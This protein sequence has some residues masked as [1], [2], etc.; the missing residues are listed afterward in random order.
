MH[1]KTFPPPILLSEL[2][3]LSPFSSHTPLA[4][5]RTDLFLVAKHQKGPFQPWVP[6][7]TR[8]FWCSRSW[9]DKRM[10]SSFF[11]EK[12][13]GVSCDLGSAAVTAR[14]QCWPHAVT[15]SAMTIRTQMTAAG[16]GFLKLGSQA[17]PPVSNENTDRAR[18]LTAL[19]FL[20]NLRSILWLER[21]EKRPCQYLT[22]HQSY[23][24]GH[25]YDRDYG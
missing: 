17:A 22:R 19:G 11:H 8:C 1:I 21:Q 25:S 23:C 5:G 9:Q 16:G 20:F 15:P 7:Q 6:T 14:G 3:G 2:G 10:Q 12:Q 4:A 24:T 13:R 18:I